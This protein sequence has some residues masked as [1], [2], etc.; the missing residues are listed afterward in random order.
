MKKIIIPAIAAAAIFAGCSKE[1]SNYDS[2]EIQ[3]ITMNAGLASDESKLAFEADGTGYKTTWTASDIVRLY[4]NNGNGQKGAR[5]TEAGDVTPKT[6]ATSAEIKFNV[7]G[8]SEISGNIQWGAYA[9]SGKEDLAPAYGYW[10]DDYSSQNGTESSA[11]KLIF[12]Y[13][14]GSNLFTDLE[15]PVTFNCANTMLKFTLTFPSEVTGTASEITISGNNIFTK[16]NY[17]WGALAAS[18]STK[19]SIAIADQAITD[20]KITFYAAVAPSTVSDVKVT[21]KVNGTAYKA[22]VEAESKALAAGKVY[23]IARNFTPA[24]TT[25]SIYEPHTVCSYTFGTGL[26]PAAGW[27]AWASYD[28]ATGIITLSADGTTGL[29]TTELNFTSGDK[30]IVNRISVEDFIGA[31]KLHS[32]SFKTTGYSNTTVVNQANRDHYTEVAIEDITDYTVNGHIANVAVTGLFLDLKLPASIEITET[33][34]KVYTYFTNN[35]Y[36]TASNG[37]NYAFLPELTNTT[38]YSTGYYAPLTFGP[39]NCNWFWLGWDV[40]IT[41]GIKIVV[42]STSDRQVTSNRWCYGISIAKQGYTEGSYTTIYQ[43]N[44]KNSI[45]WTGNGGAYFGKGE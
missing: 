14:G 5:F 3:T 45:S 7:T 16:A 26:T 11:Q 38:S 32:Y 29:S 40:D 15:S 23:N 44:W 39:D 30:V 18:A 35:E 12:Y 1:I 22:V 27:P 34:I 13:A 31:Y 20:N 28:T 9:T 19:G 17:S 2:Q 6:P 43:L 21:A 33:G 42:G 4:Y 36:M 10:T 24:A 41:S 8:L 37:S 25:V